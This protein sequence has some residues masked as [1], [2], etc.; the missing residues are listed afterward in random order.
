[1]S[2]KKGG[3]GATKKILDGYVRSVIHK[4]VEKNLG[5]LSSP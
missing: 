4:L 5:R 2:L 3:F 1:M